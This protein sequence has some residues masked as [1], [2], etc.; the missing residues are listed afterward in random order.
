MQSDDVCLN[1]LVRLSLTD[2]LG[3]L[4]RHDGGVSQMV[5]PLN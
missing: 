1:P 3:E 2:V 5:V 4:L